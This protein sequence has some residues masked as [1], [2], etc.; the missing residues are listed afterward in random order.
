[1]Y[2]DNLIAVLQIKLA[3][4]PGIILGITFSKSFAT[5]EPQL[6]HLVFVVF[7]FGNSPSISYLNT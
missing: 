7:N 4:K 3:E 5:V 6:S 1:M 2:F